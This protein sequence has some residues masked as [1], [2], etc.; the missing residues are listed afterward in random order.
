MRCLVSIKVVQEGTYGGVL[1]EI[2][3]MTHLTAKQTYRAKMKKFK[4][5]GSK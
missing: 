4:I 1:T 5:R 2:N 3:G